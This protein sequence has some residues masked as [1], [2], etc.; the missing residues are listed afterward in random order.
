MAFDL[1]PFVWSGT[2]LFPVK[3]KKRIVRKRKRR[4]ER[5]REGRKQREKKNVKKKG[6]G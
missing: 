4:N 6:E 3:D 2:I 1:F 5:N